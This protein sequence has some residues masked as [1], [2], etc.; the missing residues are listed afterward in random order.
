MKELSYH[1][2]RKYIF[3]FEKQLIMLFGKEKNH[4]VKKFNSSSLFGAIYSLKRFLKNT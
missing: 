1:A 3:I 4:L 2:F